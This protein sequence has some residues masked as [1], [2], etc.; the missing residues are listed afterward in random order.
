MEGLAQGDGGGRRETGLR[1]H[2]EELGGLGWSPL[3]RGDVGHGVQDVSGRAAQ[4]VVRLREV[5]RRGELFGVGYGVRGEEH[6]VGQFGREA[7]LADAGDDLVE[8]GGR[9]CGLGRPVHL[10][11]VRLVLELGRLDSEPR[12]AG[13]TG[14][15]WEQL[16]LERGQCPVVQGFSSSSQ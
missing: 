6:D 14:G 7:D 5:E 11:G 9:L 3:C 16:E 1:E 13:R 8:S 2:G 10:K 15:G 4:L 12:D